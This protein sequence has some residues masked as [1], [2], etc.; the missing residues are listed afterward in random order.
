MHS[1]IYKQLHMHLRLK[2]MLG[3]FSELM[4]KM[5]FAIIGRTVLKNTM[6]AAVT[7][8]Y[9]HGIHPALDEDLL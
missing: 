7:A 4:S 2:I 5:A 1:M 8:I 3:G 6:K 9:Y